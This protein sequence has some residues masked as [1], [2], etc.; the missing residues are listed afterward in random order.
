VISIW[1]RRKGR[2]LLW[3]KKQSPYILAYVS[4]FSNRRFENLFLFSRANLE[5]EGRQTNLSGCIV[6]S[7]RSDEQQRKTKI[8][9][10]MIQN[11]VG[12]K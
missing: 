1:S 12:T 6:R 9:L 3:Y 8:K 7:D 4:L 10:S 11:S 2:I 5:P